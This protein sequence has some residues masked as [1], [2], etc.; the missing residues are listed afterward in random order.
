MNSR[1][2]GMLSLTLTCLA[3]LVASPLSFA[4]SDIEGQLKETKEKFTFDG[5]AIHPGCVRQFNISPADSE[6][7]IVRA[8]DVGACISSNE[9][10]EPFRTTDKGYVLYEYDAGYG[11]KGY[12]AYKYLGMTKSGTLVID[13]LSNE[14]GTMVAMVVF[15]LDFDVEDYSFFDDAGKKK[16]G[17]RL[18]MS[19]TG[20][21]TR[22]DRDTGTVTLKDN[23]LILGKSQYRDKEE[24]IELGK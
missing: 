9:N 20:Q 1:R 21:I 7:P 19:C 13:T 14:G 16:A 2:V 24:V 6:P 5:K 10:T 3:I 12:F 17:K 8:V 11:E 18:I 22:G 15:L 4:E 23:E